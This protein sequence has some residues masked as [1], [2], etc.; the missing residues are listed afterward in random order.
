MSEVDWQNCAYFTLV[1]LGDQYV[2]A[3]L[4]LGSSIVN[5]GTRVAR[6]LCMITPDV[7]VAARRKL[8]RFWEL[9]EVEYLTKR[10]LPLLLSHRMREIY[11]SWIAHSFTKWRCIESARRLGISRYLYLDADTVVLANLDKV[12]EL[13]NCVATNFFPVFSMVSYHRNRY[14]AGRLYKKLA[15]FESD[16]SGQAPWTCQ[17]ELAELYQSY[18]DATCD[19]LADKRHFLLNSSMVYFALNVRQSECLFRF[20][21]SHVQDNLRWWRKRNTINSQLFALMSEVNSRPVAV[22]A[23]GWDEQVLAEA[24]LGSSVG[25]QVRLMH[26]RSFCN[27]NAGFWNSTKIKLQPWT[28]TWWGTNKPWND[29]QP[30]PKYVDVYLFRYFYDRAIRANGSA[31]K[32][33]LRILRA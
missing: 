27:V 19:K 32:V 20:V 6:R 8:N 24:L 3:A 2:P 23:N 16:E 14:H 30:V 4:A 7:S 9:I 18:K 25:E 1:M 29:D 13:E 5:S 15:E 28:L 10:T 21:R 17:V 26:M 33:G 22:F 12:F 31:L 11:G